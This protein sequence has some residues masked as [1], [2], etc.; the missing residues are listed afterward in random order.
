MLKV[1]G[2][3]MSEDL[4]FLLGR[5]DASAA[6]VEAV[7]AADEHCERAAGLDRSFRRQVNFV[8]ARSR[9]HG[10]RESVHHGGSA[11]SQFQRSEL[12]DEAFPVVRH[13]SSIRLTEEQENNI[14]NI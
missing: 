6:V 11:G 2:W 5:Q 14:S 12:R 8:R 4:G 3:L 9:P 13:Q 1:E 10:A 7:L